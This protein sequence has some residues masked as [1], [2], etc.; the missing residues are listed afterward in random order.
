MLS[1]REFLAIKVNGRKYLDQYLTEMQN[2]SV[3]PVTVE[4]LLNLEATYSLIEQ[5]KSIYFT[6]VFKEKNHFIEK[7]WLNGVI[8]DHYESF[9]DGLYIF[10]EYSKSCG[11]LLLSSIDNFNFQFSF[12]AEHAGL[13]TIVNNK[14]TKKLVLDFYEENNQNFL[15]I[16][17]YKRS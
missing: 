15:E 3:K 2:I 16:E 13:I 9:N 6:Q 14:I 4:N 8:A 17:L 11:A 12:E 10:T 5:L 7:E 1:K